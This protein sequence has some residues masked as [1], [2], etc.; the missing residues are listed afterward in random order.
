MIAYYGFLSALL[1]TLVGSFLNVCI[2]RIPAGLSIVKPRSRCGSCG[3]T[4]SAKEL[5]P[6][7]S[8]LIQKKACT[9]CG[10]RIS[11]RYAL[12]EAL[13][14]ALFLAAFLSYNVSAMTLMA[15][16]FISLML[17]VCFIDLDHMII[18]NKL[19]LFGMA[20][21]LAPIGL[22]VMGGYPFYPSGHVLVLILT[23]MLPFAVMF[24]LAML[25]NLLTKGSG[26][27]M[28]DVKIYIP[29]AMFLGWQ[30]GLL[31]IWLTFIFGG[32]FGL[33]WT[34]ILKKSR[35]SMIPFAPFIALSSVLLM[36]IGTKV[37]EIL[38]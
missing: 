2:Y 6:I 31:S 32:L 24:F 26:M 12:V 13:T 1:G 23:L 22:Q 7:L 5:I 30:L 28:G 37:L 20:I 38:Q 19:V 3:H 16:L 17:V 8:W 9:Q 4:L 11:S 33:L 21:G 14:G 36:L 29:I 18:P 34:L 25:S 10:V 15:W 35:K 27:G